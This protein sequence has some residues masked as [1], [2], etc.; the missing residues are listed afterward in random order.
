MVLTEGPISMHLN[1]WMPQ[2]DCPWSNFAPATLMFCEKNLCSWIAQPSNTWSN[3]AFV[4]AGIM[5]VR[6]SAGRPLLK[7]LGHSAWILGLGS[8][9][10]HAS[11]TFF[12]EVWDLLG[13]YMISGLM[14]SLNAARYWRNSRPALTVGL[15]IGMTALALA[16]LI[17]FRPIGIAL[18][19]IQITAALTLEVLMHL[20]DDEVN[21]RFAKMFIGAF[22]IA[23]LLW[24]LDIHNI[25]CDPDNHILTGHAIWHL[26]NACAIWCI[27]LFYAQ[28]KLAGETG[29]GR[30]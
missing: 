10:F 26:L 23:F 1:H 5:I 29:G 3:L 15:F 4:I 22:V 12:F 13:M 18:F 9:M 11:A 7:L 24:N 19:T 30:Q 21:F 20:R 14:V 6:A 27:Y 2:A 28:F 16:L 8:T 17:T 25:V